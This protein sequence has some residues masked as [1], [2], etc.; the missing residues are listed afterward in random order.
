LYDSYWNLIDTK[1]YLISEK[2]KVIVIYNDIFPWVLW[3]DL[4]KTTLT[5]SIDNNVNDVS[6]NT[7]LVIKDNSLDFFT[8]S[9]ELVQTG[10]LIEINSWSIIEQKILTTQTWAISELSQTWIISEINQENIWVIQLDYIFQSPSYLLEKDD[11]VSVYNCDTSKEECK[12]NLDLRNSFIWNNKEINYNCEINFWFLTEEDKKCNPW[13][14]T[15]PVWTYDFLIKITS[16][17]DLTKIVEKSFKVINKWYIKPVSGGSNIFISNVYTWNSPINISKPEIIIQSWLDENNECTNK[18]SCSVNFNYQTKN[19]SE[20][21]IWDFWTW[22]FELWNDQKCNPWYVKYGSWDFI[23]K[24]KVYQD[25]NTSN[26]NTSERRFSN[27]LVEKEIKN[28]DK[29]NVAKKEEEKKKDKKVIEKDLPIISSIIRNNIKLKINKILVNPIW[30]DDLEYIEIINKWEDVINLNGCSLDD[31]TDWWS[32]L[33]KFLNDEK[34]SKWEVKKYYKDITKLNLNNDNDEVNL[35]CDN[36]LVDKLSWDFKV[37]EWYYLDHYRLDIY[38]GKAKVIE[39]IDWDTIKIQF[40]VS[41]KVENMRLIWVDTPETKNPKT[42]VQ[43]F[44]Q[45]A[46][47]YVNDSISWEEINVEID[48]NNFRDSYSRL[49]WFVYID[50]ESFNKKLIQL[51]YAKAYLNYEFKYSDEYKKA[52]IVAKKEHLWL[53]ALSDEETSF[54]KVIKSEKNLVLGDIKSIISIQ[55]S[56]WKNKTVIWNTITCFDTCSINFDWSSSI[57]IIKKYSWDFWNGLK[58]EWKNPKNFKYDKFWTYKVYLAVSWDNWELN[59]W[60]YNVNFYQT[61]KKVKNTSLIMQVNADSK[62]WEKKYK[63]IEQSKNNLEEDNNSI[64]YYVFIAVFWV[65]LVLILLW[66]EKMV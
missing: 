33:Y 40:L 39:V 41:N 8:G 17:T 27:N 12:V 25:W 66:K 47:D 63:K 14:V 55:W 65:I 50:W 29:K 10:S 4:S 52:E 64:I 31:I 6:F 46:Y 32:K 42:D 9:I 20:K 21:C 51:W 49:L 30:S 44:W 38:S 2:W 48:P 57:W 5:W 59:I 43:K 37:K 35:F 54:Q 11:I 45:E 7:Q 22:I 53:W 28:D 19:S 24:L 3:E 61:P 15:I 58:F 36:V 1:S 62:D 60:D 26:F 23:V 18:K 13:T 34:I 56:I 16:K